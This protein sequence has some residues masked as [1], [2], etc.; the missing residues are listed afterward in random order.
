MS[1]KT[2]AA[3]SAPL[4][5]ADENLLDYFKDLESKSLETI[6]SAA[7]QIISLVTTL[8][9]LFFGVLVLRG[10]AA[11]IASFEIK[12]FGLLALL[13]YFAALFFALDVVM[14]RR[15]NIPGADLTAMR[16][17]LE[18]LFERKSHALILAQLA[19]GAATFCLLAVTL[20]LLIKL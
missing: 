7:K 13:G 18:E 17:T 6:E 4:S 20:L 12:L 1:K 5:K 9:G 15:F 16:A 8:L 14:P 3:Q 2:P 11:S 19:F 10:D